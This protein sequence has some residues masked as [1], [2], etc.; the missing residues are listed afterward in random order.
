MSLKIFEAKSADCQHLSEGEVQKVSV[1]IEEEVGGVYWG[2]G[3][4]V[5]F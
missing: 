2:G 5:E 1:I 4:Y 3:V